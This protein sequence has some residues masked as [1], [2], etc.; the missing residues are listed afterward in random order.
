MGERIIS[1]HKNERKTCLNTPINMHLRSNIHKYVK[2][3]RFANRTHQAHENITKTYK[4]ETYQGV[5]YQ[6]YL[7]FDTLLQHHQTNIVR[8]APTLHVSNTRPWL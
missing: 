3:T 2:L 4:K 5:T 1:W 6:L 8:T 7:G